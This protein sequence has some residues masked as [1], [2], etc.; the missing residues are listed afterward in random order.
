MADS[1]GLQFTLTVEALPE[2][3]FV[4]TEFDGQEHLSQPYNFTVS[5]A[6]K[7]DDWSAQDTVDKTACLTIWQDGQI[8]RKIHGVISAFTQGDTGHHFTAYSLQLSPALERLSLRHNCR[9]FQQMD[10]AEIISILLQEMAIENYAFSI[11]QP[12]AKRDYCVQYRESD[13][14]FV[15][16]LAAEEGLFYFFVQHQDKH[17]VVF[18]DDA[19]AL[20]EILTPLPYNGTAGGYR[21]VAQ[22][23]SFSL[24]SKMNSAQVQLQNYSF[25]KPGYPFLQKQHQ[26]GV[27]FQRQDYQH[28]DFPGRYIDDSQGQKFAQTRQQ[29]LNRDSI[30]ARQ[31]SNQPK[32]YSGLKFHLAQ[33]PNPSCNR[34]WQV[35]GI[36]HHG[37]Q[38]Q[39][40]DQAGTV[41]QT[42]YYN[43]AQLIPADRQW[44]AQLQTK[45]CIDGPQIALVTGPE[46]EEIY[47]DEDGRVKVQFPWDRYANSDEQASC[48]IRVAQ[49]WAGPQY[50]SMALPRIGHE[51][52]VSFVE[53]DPDQP[54]ITGRTYHST[55]PVPYSLP[56]NK[57][58]TVLRTQS[59][60]GEGYNELR[61]EDEAGQ[62]EIYWHAQKDLNQQVLSDHAMH[63]K[64]DFHRHI[65]QH[66]YNHVKGEQHHTVDG[67]QHQHVKAKQSLTV[68]GSLHI[69]AGQAWL[70]QSGQEL[71]CLAGSK[72]VLQAGSEITIK[73]GSSFVK[74][75]PAGVHLGGAAVNMNSG[76]GAASAQASSPDAVSKPKAVEQAQQL[77]PPE[78]RTIEASETTTSAS[79]PSF[80]GQDIS[81]L[82]P[83]NNA[84]ASTSLPASS[85]SPKAAKNPSGQNTAVASQQKQDVATGEENPSK[86]DDSF[87]FSM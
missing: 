21:K 49:G 25:K 8:Q 76:G 52:I 17:E 47:C 20:P 19:Q 80:Q 53:G 35:I 58:R 86:S 40:L 7:K 66:H 56:E 1:T 74:V 69:K 13:L 67:N 62:E 9:I 57:T 48:W 18:C 38:P 39:A 27:T 65:E 50:G 73:A 61:L 11:K 6:S 4:V 31:Q 22:A 32:L 44:K 10:V 64:N 43:H 87:L 84:N 41:G 78:S 14:A 5:L 63:V 45:P 71:H 28:F 72:I 70:T 36:N 26:Q 15:E 68:N 83:V 33:H 46:G 24:Q 77:T 2:S 29:L 37:S 75:D 54:I 79:Q 55:N 42:H 85:A 59:H 81:L 3:S 30:T 51:V 16:R 12:L 60:Q 82:S 34:D 23:I